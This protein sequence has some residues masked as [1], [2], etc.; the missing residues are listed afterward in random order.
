M[1]QKTKFGEDDFPRP[2]TVFVA[3]TK[4]G[5]LSAGRVLCSEFHGGAH[6]V[7]I[8]GSPWIGDKAPP[9]DLPDL[10]SIL[11]CNHHNYDS[12]PL[13]IWVHDLIPPHFI[14][15]GELELS[16]DELATSSNSYSGWEYIPNQVL[17]QWRWEHDRE[18]LVEEDARLFAEKTEAS[19]QRAA[20]RA[21]YMRT[22]TLDSLAERVWFTTWEDTDIGL[23]LDE[24]RSLIAKL[25]QEL[26]AVPKLTLT[27]A[28]RLLKQSV[29]EFNRLDAKQ[30]FINT[31]EREGLCEAYDQ[32]MAAAKFPQAA[33]QVE[34]WR[35]W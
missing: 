25:V 20:V 24:C 29:K 7:L 2:G 21:E 31:I 11:Y 9:L 14:I 15:I 4:D 6:A 3:P 32:I 22:L 23:P 30:H 34:L 28:K 27:I 17:M 5:R 8:S 19:R 35:D 13:L 18:A 33:N 12:G 1:A 10:R 16:A 26:R